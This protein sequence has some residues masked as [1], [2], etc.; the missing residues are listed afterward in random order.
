MTDAPQDDRRESRMAFA[1]TLAEFNDQRAW[2]S[3][4]AGTFKE[5]AQRIDMAIIGAGALIAVL[6]VL[7]PESATHWTAIAASILGGAIVIFQGLHRV[8]RY[9]E[10]WREYRLASERM[11]REWRMF[12]N[13]AEPYDCAETEAQRLYI[14]NLEKII[15]EEQKIFFDRIHNPEQDQEKGAAGGH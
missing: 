6:P 11:K 10:I 9:S 14:T 5:R 12:V 3:R 1:D 15:A 4:K 8:F 7:K 2:Y 13:R